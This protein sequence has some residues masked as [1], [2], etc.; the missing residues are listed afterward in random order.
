VTAVNFQTEA[1]AANNFWL[2]MAALI[3]VVAGLI[4]IAANYVW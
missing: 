1:R 4:A 3:I 2:Q